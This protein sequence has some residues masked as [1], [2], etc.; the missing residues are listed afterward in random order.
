MT[1]I[2][3]QERVSRPFG[4]SL[5][6]YAARRPEVVCLTNDLT[7]SVE[8]DDFRSA[9]PERFFS[10]GMAEQNLIGVAAGMAR[11]GWIPF[12]PTFAVFA[13]RRPYEQIAMAVAYPA[14]P[15]RL[16]GFL[17]GLLTPG[18]P[19]H[20]A[21]D[22]IGLMTQLPNMTVLDLSDATDVEAAAEAT[23][24][25]HGPVYCRMLRGEVPRRFSHPFELG[26]MRRL[27]SGRDVLIV[28]SGV[29]IEAAMAAAAELEAA[30]IDVGHAHVTTLKPFEDPTLVQAIAEVRFGVVTVENHL[31][32]GGLGTAVAEMIADHGIGSRLIRIGIRDTFTHGGTSNYLFDCYGLGAPAVVQAVE[33]LTD[34]TAAAGR[35]FERPTLATPQ[36]PDVSAPRIEVAEGL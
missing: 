17:P 27:R 21:T 36:R 29:A 20:Q 14:L 32:R 8:A 19:T 3:A 22:D 4:R 35:T 15:V 28:S 7:A 25:I 9:Y 34:P 12:Y 2:E 5:V 10:M 6:A 18:G 24:H 26:R 11:E 30:G 16:C 13:T 1:A 31:I 23:D 33:Q